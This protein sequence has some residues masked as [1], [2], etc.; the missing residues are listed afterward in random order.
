[1]YTIDCSDS[2]ENEV[3]SYL[4]DSKSGASS[5]HSST[6]SNG[7]SNSTSNNE[8]NNTSNTS[9]ES[10]IEFIIDINRTSLAFTKSVSLQPKRVLKKGSSISTR[11]QTNKHVKNKYSSS[12]TGT[13]S[14]SRQFNSTNNNAANGVADDMS[15]LL[16]VALYGLH[17]SK[18]ASIV[19]CKLGSLRLFDVE[20]LPSVWCGSDPDE[21]LEDFNVIS[22]DNWNLALFL[23]VNFFK[24][25]ISM[26]STSSLPTDFLLQSTTR[27]EDNSNTINGGGSGGGN[28][29]GNTSFTR[30]NNNNNVY[31]TDNNNNHHN[32]SMNRS[33]VRMVIG[34]DNSEFESFETDETSFSYEQLSLSY[35]SITNVAK[36]ILMPGLRAKSNLNKARNKIDEELLRKRTHEFLTQQVS[37]HIVLELKIAMLT[38][39]SELPLIETLQTIILTSMNRINLSIAYSEQRFPTYS[40]IDSNE[41]FVREQQESMLYMNQSMHSLSESRHDGMN[42]GGN[43]SIRNAN[44]NVYGNTDKLNL[45]KS[46]TG[47]LNASQSSMN[48]GGGGS[49]IRSS[50][51]TNGAQ[52]LDVWRS[53]G[54]NRL[55]VD[56]TCQGVSFT[57]PC[58]GSVQT[59]PVESSHFTDSGTQNREEANA[60]LNSTSNESKLLQ[61]VFMKMSVRSGDHLESWLNSNINDM[62]KQTL[63][64]LQS[65]EA[66]YDT[67]KKDLRDFH[68]QLNSRLPELNHKFRPV[69]YDTIH[70]QQKKRDKS[71]SALLDSTMANMGD[72]TG[73]G[74]YDDDSLDSSQQGGDS[75]VLKEP[76]VAFIWGESDFNLK[77]ISRNVYEK[78]MP[79]FVF[80]LPHIDI[81]VITAT[82]TTTC[83][84]WRDVIG[85][86]RESLQSSSAIELATPSAAITVTKL[87]QVPWSISGVVGLTSLASYSS[88]SPLQ[89]WSNFSASNSNT[90][91]NDG[92]GEQ[93]RMQRS[94][95]N[96]SL[97]LTPLQ[98]QPYIYSYP[99][100][101]QLDIFTTPLHLALSI[102]DVNSL[103]DIFK[104]VHHFL[105]KVRHTRQL[106]NA[107]S[108]NSNDNSG[109]GSGTGSGGGTGFTLNKTSSMHKVF[110]GNESFDLNNSVSAAAD[111]PS[112]ADK[113]EA[114]DEAP[115]LN[116]ELHLTHTQM[117]CCISF[118]C[119]HLKLITDKE[120]NIKD[121]IVSIF[122][123]F[124]NSAI[125][126]KH[127]CRTVLTLQSYA[128]HR[129]LQ[130]GFT[131]EFGEEI[132]NS[133]FS[134]L[135]SKPATCLPELTQEFS[136][137]IYRFIHSKCSRIR[138]GSDVDALNVNSG[139]SNSVDNGDGGYDDNSS[140]SG[141]SGNNTRTFFVPPICCIHL[142]HI[143]VTSEI[144]NYDT[145]TTLGMDDVCVTDQE[146]FPLLHISQLPYEFLHTHT[147]DSLSDVNL[148][149]NQF[150]RRY[151]KPRNTA[152]NR[153][154]LKKSASTTNNSNNAGSGNNISSGNNAANLL[155]AEISK[156]RFQSNS[157][158]VVQDIQ[159]SYEGLCEHS[160]NNLPVE[161][162]K[163]VNIMIGNLHDNTTVCFEFNRLDIAYLSSSQLTLVTELLK[164]G[165]EVESRWR[166]SLQLDDEESTSG[167]VNAST[168]LGGMTGTGT[169][170]L[171]G[172]VRSSQYQSTSTALNT[173]MNAASNNI[174][175][176]GIPFYMSTQDGYTNSYSH[177]SSHNNITH[178]SSSGPSDH[179]YHRNI[180]THSP[181]PSSSSHS[182]S[183]SHSYIQSNK[184]FSSL[185]A[186]VDHERMQY[187]QTQQSKGQRKLFEDDLDEQ[188]HLHHQQ[189]QQQSPTPV[190]KSSILFKFDRISITLGRNNQILTQ[191]TLLST[192]ASILKINLE[193]DNSSNDDNRFN[194]SAKQVKFSEKKT[195]ICRS[196]IGFE[197]DKIN[198]YDLSEAGELHQRVIWNQTSTESAAVIAD[199]N[200]AYDKQ[201]NFRV[202][203]LRCRFVNRFLNEIIDV[204][205]LDIVHPLQAAT[206]KHFEDSRPLRSGSVNPSIGITTKISSQRQ[207]SQLSTDLQSKYK[208]EKDKSFHLDNS[209]TG[210]LKSKSNH[211]HTHSEL[212]YLSLGSGNV[213]DIDGLSV[214]GDS[215]DN[216]RVPYDDG[217]SD[218]SDS[219]DNDDGSN[220]GGMQFRSR[221]NTVAIPPT[222]TQSKTLNRHQRELLIQNSR[223]DINTSTTTIKGGLKALPPPNT[224]IFENGPVQHNCTLE[225]A[226]V[227]VYAP[228]NSCSTDLAAVTIEHLILES[229][230]VHQAWIEP[231]KK[232]GKEGSGDESIECPS[233]S[234]L[235]YDIHSNKWTHLPKHD[236]HLN[237][238]SPKH[239]HSPFNQF[240]A[241]RS[242]KKSFSI[243]GSN[244]NHYYN[245]N[246]S[247]N[248]AG[249]HALD[250]PT[251]SSGTGT[252]A[253]GTI[254]TSSQDHFSRLSINGY[255]I[256]IYTSLSGRFTNYEGSTNADYVSGTDLQ[257]DEVHNHGFVYLR[258]KRKT[259]HITILRKQIWRRVTDEPFHLCVLHDRSVGKEVEQARVL[260]S[261]TPDFSI[262]SLSLS[263][264][265]L[266]LLESVYFDNYLEVTQ[267]IKST[268]SIHARNTM[269]SPPV[270]GYASSSSSTL[271]SGAMKTQ[272]RSDIHTHTTSSSTTGTDNN[273]SSSYQ[274]SGDRSRL[275]A[276]APEAATQT[277]T[278]ET[279]N[280]PSKLSNKN[281]S[282]KVKIKNSHHESIK[283]IMNSMKYKLPEYGSVNY[284]EVLK[285]RLS[286]VSVLIVRAEVSIRCFIDCEYFMKP[287]PSLGNILKYQDNPMT[288]ADKHFFGSLNDYGYGVMEEIP[289]K[290]EALDRLNHAH[291]QSKLQQQQ[292]HSY[293]GSQH[294]HKSF[295]KK[296]KE[297]WTSFENIA[298][299]AFELYTAGLMFSV[300][301]ME[302]AT[303]LGVAAG[304]TEIWDIRNPMTTLNPFVIKVGHHLFKRNSNVA[305]MSASPSA[306]LLHTSVRVGA[307][308]N[309]FPVDSHTASSLCFTGPSGFYQHH[310]RPTHQPN[311]TTTTAASAGFDSTDRN[312]IGSLGSLGPPPISQATSTSHSHVHS[313]HRHGGHYSHRRVYTRRYFIADN[314][315]GL[316][317]QP[318]DVCTPL[319]APLQLSVLV[320]PVGNWTTTNVG[321]NAADGCLSNM[322]MIDM[323]VEFFAYYF[324]VPEVSA[325]FVV[326]TY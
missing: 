221:R 105:R 49:G 30:R 233:D 89:T 134:L 192:R 324:Q 307:D 99:T 286:L 280:F 117:K 87:T 150:L 88:H 219:S 85:P 81:S 158:T 228:R 84:A 234:V 207:H 180:H 23:S 257:P 240:H 305:T 143:K 273:N 289:V 149:L 114:S 212:D 27:T 210:T 148:E 147:F 314:D 229:F 182:H 247:S 107:G 191:L 35:S 268:V 64:R 17:C 136:D 154:N 13:G 8:E 71:V 222:G 254:G 120:V 258:R 46:Q 163:A 183:H 243:S 110:N 52:Q 320:S 301:T 306:D 271:S 246:L 312:T 308:A 123:D 144:S 159:S 60:Q 275:T 59:S 208:L 319:S 9:T 146:G 124:G 69:W 56:V 95:S 126:K 203:G 315:F 39:H 65:E 6:S 16:T 112:E 278:K 20:G 263:I 61:I 265:E 29:I 121:S 322:H 296:V 187:Q 128:I 83:F 178:N 185:A 304:V 250:V 313:Q 38:L 57:I 73:D 63:T 282:R 91:G 67:T 184:P 284:F 227:V 196:S 98:Q 41:Y 220:D 138:G 209:I 132:L 131:A 201:C 43:D 225:I 10:C 113:D 28:I 78:G 80:S 300:E 21:W 94:S 269:Q 79:P 292:Q 101:S 153:F 200:H 102:E 140:S 198:L 44:T 299:P 25:S 161:E 129:L 226:D 108:V 137:Y 12:N 151:E 251:S 5:L 3:M 55:S 188:Y 133:Y 26:A 11:L 274:R 288:E 325:L 310:S 270:P 92:R 31:T 33:S 15:N 171:F 70:L 48:G 68:D 167:A 214:D 242:A 50:S 168:E 18:D 238:T 232:E 172:D 302:D 272:D 261:D 204:I 169:T 74:G 211:P 119:L 199:I 141:R 47:R 291:K 58:F 283:A 76:K 252:G 4:F 72:G 231:K 186:G 165:L 294:T 115:N 176:N 116:R 53:N 202:H 235:Y 19:E 166:H 326:M 193:T 218:S 104:E 111:I 93:S 82:K 51:N 62:S 173:S 293:Y 316:N 287:P 32:D 256:H 155:T 100:H 266:A 323:L 190:I 236:E 197:M 216:D 97:G 279:N 259:D 281:Q 122:K 142:E 54:H 40:N 66:M 295:S 42:T 34:A 215:S 217:S 249:V 285:S 253:A 106:L 230:E 103:G 262:L 213:E 45:S 318:Q 297:E 309:A 189:Q 37:E 145:V 130:L 260:I 248:A 152:E 181:H 290:R 22:S 96:T 245:S 194:N 24:S 118:D 206:L 255:N 298:L 175:G 125:I 205:S 264:A 277:T 1:M 224:S 303:S 109:R 311:I 75:S 321:I 2:S 139:C 174:S 86:N 170:N 177:T 267:F 276:T 179:S 162:R 317:L 241:S 77:S 160:S 7:G 90:N 164:A 36:S 135:S 244:S 14:T 127:S 237:K 239:Y 223:K 156:K 195:S 157:V